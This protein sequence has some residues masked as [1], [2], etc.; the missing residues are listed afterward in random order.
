MFHMTRL[1]YT[2]WTA[3]VLLQLLPLPI[4]QLFPQPLNVRSELSGCAVQRFTP[5]Y[6]VVDV[7]DEGID[8]LLF[9]INGSGKCRSDL[10]TAD[11]T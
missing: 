10:D 11:I 2:L 6:K 8:L 3:R 5:L 4:P 1:K 7:I 9:G